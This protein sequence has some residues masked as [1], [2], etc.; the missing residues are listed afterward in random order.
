MSRP[1]QVLLAVALVTVAAG[2]FASR[3]EFRGSF[4]ELLPEGAPEV[5]DLTRVSEKAGGDGYLVI[6]A[7]GAAPEA[8]K[9]YAT[10][11]QRRLEA[12]PTVR[13]VE[14]HYDVAFFRR[15][16][17]LLLPTAEVA[18]LRQDLEARV[19][20]EKERAS[21]LFVDLGT[22]E[23]PP[24]FEEIARKH[25]PDT[26]LPETLANKEGTEVYL[27]IK[28]SGTAG[29]LEFAR[30]F[31]ATVFDTGRTLAAEKY[32][33][34]T[35]EATGNFQN[36]I[37]EDA[38]MR[39][40][41]SNAGL[42]SALIAVGLILLATR[43]ISALAVVGVP[44][45]VGLV[46]T[47]AFAQGAIGHL[48]IVT[49]FLVAILIG[50]GIEYGVH[51]AM[52]YWE[53]REQHGVKEALTAA[54]R[55]TF[56]GALT[57]AFTNAAAFF[58]LVLAQFHA[59]QQFGL[60]AGVGVLMA[61][62][63]AYALGPSLLAIAE[64]IRPFRRDAAPAAQ[65]SAPAAAQ[66]AEQA[67]APAKE[68]RRWPTGVIVAVALSVV[69][70]AAYSV[71]IAPRLG[72][73]T[74]LR[75]LKG[76]SPASRL[77][78]HIT[79]QI[80]SP[81]NPAIL[82]VDTL[83][84]VREV[85]AVIAQVKAKNGA[86]SVFLRTASLSDL[87][88]SDVAGHEAEMD[89]IRT[90]LDGLP[91]SA[92]E[93]PRVKDL[94]EMVDAKPYGL[95]QLPVEARRRFEALDGKGMFLLLFPSVS[96]YDT[97]DLNRWAGQ[98]NEVIAGAKEKGID[99]AVLDSNRIAARIFSLVRG[100]GPFILWSAAVVVFLVILAS[101]RSFK[102]ALLVAGPLFLGMTCLAGGMY[103]FDVQLNFINAVVLPN[104][105]AIAVDNSVH[106][107]HRYE[108]EGPGSLGRVVRN[109]GFA[110]VVATL[111]NA[112]GYGALLVANH[113][114]LRSIGQIAL[115]GVVSTFLGTTVFFPAMLA[116]LERWKGRRSAVAPETGAVVRS[117][118]LGGAGELPAESPGER[119]SA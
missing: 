5:R 101:L 55:G 8:L 20:Y 81:L 38:V 90:L 28:P 107:F 80:G 71:G 26:A 100:D 22:E 10:E 88:P 39:R 15:H 72:F 89:G 35:L 31:V 51:L 24:T 117:L 96:N 69:G 94:R 50:L 16:G 46:L 29:D 9:A 95:D 6:M 19:R 83:E 36:R 17:L 7:K 112:A 56:S 75:N 21:P 43:R 18:S 105:L 34:V 58:V 79:E 76:D 60:L 37:E 66:N 13:Y 27:M 49:G 92:Q 99:L 59:F 104:L 2:F 54:V 47:F 42:L 93:D 82:A 86:N 48:N 65:A 61:V 45:M 41:L 84:Q 11:F 102:R 77:D 109:T 23:A 106:L 64:R 32:P 74:N 98:L 67:P 68:W 108:E 113:Q 33:G 63:S 4:V 25:T 118:N 115:L 111:S 78:D 14:H 73:E 40:D 57:S 12:L 87:V 44:V 110:A 1:W 70:F 53:E 30:N 114:G 3:L 91:K 62:L 116:L 85:E 52:R 97:Q 119:K 103:L